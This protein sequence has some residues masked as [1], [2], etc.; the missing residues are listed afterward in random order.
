MATCPLATAESAR[1]CRAGHATAR[2]GTHGRF[3]RR[4]HA[5][6][7]AR[8][9]RDGP[10]VALPAILGTDDPLGRPVAPAR[11]RRPPA[12]TRPPI[13]PTTS[14]RRRSRITAVVRDEQGQAAPDAVVT[15]QVVPAPPVGP[16]GSTL[17]AVPGAAGHYSAG[18]TRPKRPAITKSSCRPSWES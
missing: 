4:H 18:S 5:Q 11:S 17:S 8:S 14:P 1:R 3:L 13:R 15:A 9:S 7:A 2:R 6:V 16:T 12:S 10:G